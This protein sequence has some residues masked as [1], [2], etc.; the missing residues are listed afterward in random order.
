MEV[1]YNGCIGTDDLFIDIDLPTITTSGDV[2][3]CLGES[4]PLTVNGDVGNT[5]TWSPNFGLNDASSATPIANPTS[6]IK[7]V[8]TGTNTNSC[9]I[10]DS[11]IVT[12]NNPQ[13]DILGDTI[14]IC[15]GAQEQINILPNPGTTNIQWSSNLIGAGL[16]CTSNCNNPTFTAADT[17]TI[18]LTYEYQ[19]CTFTEVIYIDTWDPS[20]VDAGAD[21]LICVGDTVSLNT[22]YDGIVEWR[23]GSLSNSALF[24]AEVNPVNNTW[25]YVSVTRYGCTGVDSLLIR[26]NTPTLEVDQPDP[27]CVGTTIPL[28]VRGVSDPDM[29]FVWDDAQPGLS[30]L[31]CNNPIATAPFTSTYTVT[32]TNSFGCTVSEDV[33]VIVDQDTID[34]MPDTI[35]T[36]INSTY[37]VLLDIVNNPGV[38]TSSIFWSTL[39]PIDCQCYHPQLSIDQSGP[40]TLS[41]K[42][43]SCFKMEEVYVVAWDPATVDA[44][45]DQ[46]VCAGEEVQLNTNFPGNVQWYYGSMTNASLAGSTDIPT[47]SG[48]YY[49]RVDN[50][51][52]FGIDSMDVTVLPNAD[53]SGGQYAICEGDS[54]QVDVVGSADTILFNNAGSISDPNSFSPWASPTITT[55]YTVV[56]QNNGCAQDT[57]MIEVIVNENPFIDIRLPAQFIEGDEI[58]LQADVNAMDNLNYIWTPGVMIDCSS[59]QLPLFRPTASTLVSLTVTNDDTGCMAVDTATITQKFIC[60]ENSIGVASAFSPNNDGVNDHIKPVSLNQITEFKIFNR[61]GEMVFR[62]D[63]SGLGWDGRYN[64]VAVKRGVYV[65]VASGLCRFDGTPLQAQGDFMLVR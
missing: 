53:I 48:R 25:Y 18:T 13:S 42:Y 40:M 43:N 47:Q 46:T 12:V 27:I 49:L 34:L 21:Q 52:C 44:G 28:F 19:A 54:V 15:L 29:T 22:N 30:C 51:T 23:E 9:T 14:K 32:G 35:Y 11:L 65:Y 56:G 58:R 26:L 20:T 24:V 6:T 37:E 57:A 1:S 31:D 5:Y 36:C 64:G 38:D 45:A 62:S 17:G 50:N 16:T 63:A 7:Y 39:I 3:I 8:V 61:W 41:Y 10:K 55:T 2:T 60:G 4:T 59:C 33:T